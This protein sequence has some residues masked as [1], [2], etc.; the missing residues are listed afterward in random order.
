MSELLKIIQ[1][2]ALER[3]NENPDLNPMMV[4]KD[5]M[6]IVHVIEFAWTFLPQDGK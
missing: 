6:S 5:L 4:W 3:L 1:M 2:N